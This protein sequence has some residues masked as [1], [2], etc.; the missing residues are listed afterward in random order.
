MIKIN[1]TGIK[2]IN[3][4]FINNIHNYEYNEIFLNGIYKYLSLNYNIRYIR[5]NENSFSVVLIKNVNNF[6]GQYKFDCMYLCDDVFYYIE[7]DNDKL[8]INRILK[9][10]KIHD[11]NK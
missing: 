7:N 11:N 9:L 8:I 5:I 6:Y 2:K 3:G 1:I 10:Q 4:I